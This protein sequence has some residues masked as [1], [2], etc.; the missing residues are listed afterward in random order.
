MVKRYTR[1]PFPPYRHLPGETPHPER[2]PGGHLYRARE[3]AAVP[4]TP[5]GW[6]ENE[7]FLF[8]VDLFNAGYFWEAHAYWERLWT[9]EATP[10]DVRR[11]LRALIQTAA[12]CLKL[13]QGRIAG[14]RKLLDRAGLEGLDGRRLGIDLQSL[15]RGARGFVEA[16][17]E[18]PHLVL[19][20]SDDR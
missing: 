19:A 9:L 5:E 14:A 11:L 10:R 18:P 20:A 17:A 12:A 6:A 7:D 4:L 16:G 2:S 15:A 8:A 13:R 3:P 1:R